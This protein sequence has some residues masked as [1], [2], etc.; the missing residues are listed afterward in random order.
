[1]ILAEKIILS[2]FFGGVFMLL[3]QLLDALLLKPKRRRLKLQKQGIRGPIPSLMCGNIAELKRIQLQKRPTGGSVEENQFGGRSVVE[4]AWTSAVFPHIEQWRREYGPTFMYSTGNIQILCIT[5]PGMVKEISLRTSLSLGKPS[6]LSTE[7][8]PLLGRGILSS[9][10]P[11]WDNQRKIIAPEFYLERVKGFVTLMAESTSTMLKTWESKA[12][13]WGGKVEIRVDEDLRSLSADIISRSCFGSNYAEGE[14]IFSKLQTLQMVMSRGNIGIPGLRY[15][16]NRHN[17]EIWR[18]E[19]EIDSTIL[20]LVERRS[21]DTCDKDLLQLILSA[22]KS[23]GDNGN[24]PA[25]ITPNKFIV[26]NCKNIYFAGHET[27]AISASWCLM[28][29]AAHPEW[30]ARARAEVLEICGLRLP[31]ADTLRS[32]KTVSP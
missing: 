13:N 17:R 24:L 26:D 20:E 31:A 22:A 15:L 9:N 3:L 8:G 14:K 23:Y 4:H 10:G 2:L 32:L 19:K 7:R 5:D 30:Q 21:G 1:M 16:P 25:D 29:L 28:L 11:Y 6:Y 27:T 18:L 12:E